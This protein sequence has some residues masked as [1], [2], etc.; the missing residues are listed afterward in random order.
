MTVEV[1]AVAVV[2]GKQHVERDVGLDL[3]AVGVHKRLLR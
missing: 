3:G 2:F 1:A